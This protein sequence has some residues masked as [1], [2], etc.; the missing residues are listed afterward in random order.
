MR[1]I[2]QGKKP[3]SITAISIGIPKGGKPGGDPG[4]GLPDEESGSKFACPACGASLCAKEDEPAG[5]NDEGGEPNMGEGAA[6][7]GRYGA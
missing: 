2:P 3:P 1:D 6:P 7:K 5:M 4:G